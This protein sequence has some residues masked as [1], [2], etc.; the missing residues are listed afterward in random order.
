MS[1]FLRLAGVVLFVLATI[2][3]GWR[4]VTIAPLFLIA[5]GLAC[6]CAASLVT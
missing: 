4:D 3:A 5:A 6:W 1:T 2:A